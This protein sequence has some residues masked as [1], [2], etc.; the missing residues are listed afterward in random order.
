M[1][2]RFDIATLG[3]PKIDQNG[4]LQAPAALTKTGVF[5][6]HRP[7]GTV[8]RELR[9]PDDVFKEDSL[10]TLKHRPFTDGHPKIG[11]LDQTNTTQLSK[12]MIIADPKRED[13]FVTSTVLVM[14]GR[15]INKINRKDKPVRELSCGYNV[16]LVE[17]SG[18]YN[19]EKYDHR[20]T[21]IVYNH[22][23]L[24]PKGR[25]GP[26]ARLRVD[27]EDGAAE[28]LDIEI[29]DKSDKLDKQNREDHAMS[30][31]I[32]REA[33]ATSTFKA[34]AL[35]V[36]VADED[37]EKS[38]QPALD[39]FDAALEHI[40]KLEAENSQMKGRIDELVEK[41]ELPPE[42]LDQLGQERADLLS[43]AFHVGLSNVDKLRNDEIKKMVV[44]TVNPKL[45]LDK[46]DQPYIDG[47][48]DSIV[49]NIQKNHKAMKSMSEL[50][51]M[52]RGDALLDEGED[53]RS[54]REAFTQDTANLW[55]PKEDRDQLNS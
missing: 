42:R 49:D 55:M 43:V 7:D 11:K 21:N 51:Q 30:I 12:G 38:I 40:R 46:V 3:E 9:H 8:T 25:A 24:V 31:K 52:T 18:T 13:Q 22:V 20:Q 19:G 29:I 47:R 53:V 17:E 54:P 45:E 6:Y 16:D 28:G 41:A 35:H 23:A 2:L 36:V 26:D 1:P 48:Y 5:V 14:D 39:R 27:A 37:A 15:T 4:Y 50:R 10:A 32:K 44:H 33:V 34:D